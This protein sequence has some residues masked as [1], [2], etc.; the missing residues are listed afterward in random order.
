MAKGSCLCG[1]VHFTAAEFTAGIFKCHCSKC[2]K[3]FGGASSA[4]ALCDEAQFSWDA[5]EAQISE[6]LSDSGFLRRFCSECGCILPQHLP[7]YASYWIP[8]G[9]LDDEP[10]LTLKTHI[11]V[12]SRATWE[13][14][15][16]HTPRLA[17]GF[18]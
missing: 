5:G 6:H 9:L 2:R 10:P 16:E 14:L 3:A 7:D 11:Y 8:V 18:N 1:S 12:D 13:V 17:E 15:D 4:A